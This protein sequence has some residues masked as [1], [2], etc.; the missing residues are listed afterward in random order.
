L[1]KEALIASGINEK[2][3]LDEYISKLAYLLE[4]FLHQT[5][6]PSDSLSKAKALFTWLWIEKPVRYA[7]HGHFKLNDVIDAQLSMETQTVGNCLGLTLLYN[8]LLCRMDIKAGAIYLENAFEIGPHVLSVL[9]TEEA[10]IDIENIL[11]DGFDYKGH[12][13]DPS[14]VRWWDEELVADIYHSLGNEF[15]EKSDFIQAL[16]YY[17]M[18][19]QFNPYYEKARLNKAILLDRIS[20][21][22]NGN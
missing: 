16:R 22:K 20:G 9:E 17:D 11:P 6:P 13:D 15:F 2:N 18:A 5:I 12:L 3:K 10:L 14:R 1:E 4:S 7:F 19:I 8:C 21:E